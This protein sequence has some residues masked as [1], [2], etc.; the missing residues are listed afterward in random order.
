MKVWTDAKNRLAR[1]Q[2]GISGDGTITAD[3][4]AYDEP[5]KIEVPAAGEVDENW[6]TGPDCRPPSRRSV[7]KSPRPRHWAG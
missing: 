3:F 2:V 4:F 1:F 7:R 6:Y 5:V